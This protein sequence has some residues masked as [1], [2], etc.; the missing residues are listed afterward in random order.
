MELIS[1]AD[2]VLALGTGSI[3]SRPSVLR[4]RLLARRAPIIQVDINP[5]R[6][7]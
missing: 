1:R 7:D 4:D 2:V 3:P 6:S 5:D